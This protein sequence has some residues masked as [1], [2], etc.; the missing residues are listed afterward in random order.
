[1]QPHSTHDRLFAA[2]VLYLPSISSAISPKDILISVRMPD[3]LLTVLSDRKAVRLRGCWLSH[4][5]DIFVPSPNIYVSMLYTNLFGRNK[6]R[7]HYI[8]YFTNCLVYYFYHMLLTPVKSFSLKS[9]YHLGNSVP[10]NLWGLKI[11]IKFCQNTF[12][13]I[14]FSQIQCLYGRAR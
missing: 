13:K 7:L 11:K 2:L 1:M 5:S 4:G 6:Q 12:N 8:F 14:R 3:Y 9:F 10:F